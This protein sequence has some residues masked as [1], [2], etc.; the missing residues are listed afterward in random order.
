MGERYDFNYFLLIHCA[1]LMLYKMLCTII[2]RIK[3]KVN[4]KVLGKSEGDIRNI[5]GTWWFSFVMG[6]SDMELIKLMPILIIWQCLFQR[7]IIFYVSN[8]KIDSIFV[9]HLYMNGKITHVMNFSI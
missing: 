7:E 3:I 6:V 5:S 2:Y 9:G 1:F 8:K 4:R